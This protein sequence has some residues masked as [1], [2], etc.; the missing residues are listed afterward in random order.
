MK[1]KTLLQITLAAVLSLGLAS[2]ALAGGHGKGKN[3]DNTAMQ[4]HREIMQSLTQEQRA[5]M[6]QTM[7]DLWL[8]GSTGMEIHDAMAKNMQGF[9]LELPDKPGKGSHKGMHAKSPFMPLGFC[10][11]PL[12]NQLTAEQRVEM[13]TLML[14]QWKAGAAP[15]EIHASVTG[16]LG[17]WGI[18]A[19]AR[20]QSGQRGKGHGMQQGVHQQQRKQ[21]MESLT[22]EQRSELHTAMLEMFL[23]GADRD[24]MRST[25]H[26]KLESY[27][28]DIPEDCFRNQQG[29]GPGG[30][31]D[32]GP[33]G[34]L[35]ISGDN[36]PNPFNPETTIQYELKNAGDVQVAIYDTNGRMI[37]TLV[38]GYQKDGTH[39]VIWD[40]MND[41]GK[42]VATGTY[43]YQITSGSETLTK[44]MIML[45]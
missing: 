35:S 3:S 31:M 20:D 17:K 19:P 7:Y 38:D 29:F 25:V 27:G 23:S 28:V 9:G 10:N 40:G 6:H 21:M 24:A 44:K 37:R 4:K 2:F 30:F 12:A 36:Y 18:E 42:Q 34:D 22:M 14:N 11:G 5:E 8:Q 15:D 1:A 45:K 26:A 43:F 41:T 39:E 16:L 32:G 13:R 33:F